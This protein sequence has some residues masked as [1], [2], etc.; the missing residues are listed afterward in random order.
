MK[1]KLYL[2]DM[3]FPDYGDGWIIVRSFSDAVYMVAE[4][5]YP[6][7]IS[8]D[9]DLGV[10]MSG[11]DF[12]KWLINRDMLGYIIPDGFKYYCHS[13]NPVGRNNILGLLDSYFAN[14]K[15]DKL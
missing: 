11:M 4:H 1:Y 7:T 3:R 5:G 13:A 14:K 12:A 15:G 8:F 6:Q 2:D 10:G 9:H